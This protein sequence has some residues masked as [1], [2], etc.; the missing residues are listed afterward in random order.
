MQN[1]D[2][3]LVNVH[4]FPLGALVQVLASYSH[5][6]EDLLIVYCFL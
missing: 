5:T 4:P 1:A 3:E 6:H 2:T